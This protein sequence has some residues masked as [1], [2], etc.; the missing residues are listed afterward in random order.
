MAQGGF[1]G[2]PPRQD[3]I[4]SP[5][6][7]DHSCDPGTGDREPRCARNPSG[8]S[9]LIPSSNVRRY[10]GTILSQPA[11]TRTDGASRREGAVLCASLRR[12]AEAAATRR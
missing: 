5:S 1:V 6:D 7:E 10:M 8:L 3:A 9:T 11:T 2:R 4:A 12:L